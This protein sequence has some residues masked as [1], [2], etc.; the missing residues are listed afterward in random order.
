[1]RW[2]ARPEFPRHSFCLSPLHVIQ[3]SVNNHPSHCKVH[4]CLCIFTTELWALSRMRSVLI[5][6]PQKVHKK[7][8][9]N[10]PMPWNMFICGL[11][12]SLGLNSLSGE[13]FWVFS[14][15]PNNVWKVKIVL[16]CPLPLPLF[17]FL[18]FSL[19]SRKSVLALTLR[20][21]D[22]GPISLGVFCCFPLFWLFLRESEDA[23]K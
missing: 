21:F 22:C 18:F 20:S 13:K 14:N 17:L 4:I 8:Y 12:F 15:V 16:I 5:I 9:L 1:M 2:E 11:L 6:N 3:T 23:L 19:R 10:E 7:C